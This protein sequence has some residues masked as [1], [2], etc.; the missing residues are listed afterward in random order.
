MVSLNRRD[1]E[2]RRGR[3]FYKEARKVGVQERAPEK[4]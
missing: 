4:N 1:A 3:F 2:A